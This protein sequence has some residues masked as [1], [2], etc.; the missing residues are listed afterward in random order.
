MNVTPTVEVYRNKHNGDYTIVNFAVDKK[1]GF[2]IETGPRIC[3]VVTEMEE[4][5]LEL[6]LESLEGF[7]TRDSQAGGGM[8][9]LSEEQQTSFY[10]DHQMVSISLEDD[11]L[12]L[13][14]MQKGEQR[15]GFVGN[16]GD[17][18]VFQLPIGP[19][20]FYEALMGRFEL[21]R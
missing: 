13:F 20:E 1:F 9:S 12:C 8:A 15:G 7:A 2:A 11:S 3:V 5:G 6:V 17:D 21:C 10:R 4:K 16:E 19:R 14:A 18:I